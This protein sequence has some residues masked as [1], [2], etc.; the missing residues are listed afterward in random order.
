MTANNTSLHSNSAAG[1]ELSSPLDLPMQHASSSSGWLL[2]LLLI[3][4]LGLVAYGIW[5]WEAQPS[6]E[7]LARYHFNA[8]PTFESQTTQTA[9]IQIENRSSQLFRVVGMNSC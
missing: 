8:F 9:E 1:A 5:N 7:V 3:A 4:A 6:S 2:R